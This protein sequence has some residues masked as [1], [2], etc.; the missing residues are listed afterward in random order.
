L[1]VVAFGVKRLDRVFPAGGGNGNPK[2]K[3]K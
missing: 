1:G 2:G 3:G